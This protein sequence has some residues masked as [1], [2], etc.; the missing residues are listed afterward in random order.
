MEKL[1]RVI[2]S[3]AELFPALRRIGGWHKTNLASCPQGVVVWIGRRSPGG[4]YFDGA[5][6]SP[7][8]IVSRPAAG[9]P[10]TIP[11]GRT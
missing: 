10:G 4:R 5:E 3:P 11:T 8:G 7:V 9:P 6:L 1:L 2:A